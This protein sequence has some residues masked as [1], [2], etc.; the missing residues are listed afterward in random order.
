VTELDLRALGIWR[1]PIPLPGTHPR[2]TVNAWAIEDVDGGLALLD[3]GFDAPESVAALAD[4]LDEGGMSFHSVRR[5][6]L[7]HAHAEHSGG[8]RRVID[9]ADPDVAVHASRAQAVRLRR[10]CRR[11]YPLRDGERL[12]F[13]WFAASAL[14]MPGHTAGLTCLFAED[15]GVF[16]S[17]DHLL[18]GIVP[19]VTCAPAN[20]DL[21]EAYRASLLRLGA[22]EVRVV[23]PGRGA[24]FAGHRRV[25]GEVLASL[26]HEGRGATPAPRQESVRPGACVAEGT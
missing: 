21:R 18:N 24:P 14:R 25:V 2:E 12:R 3:C 19:V 26:A 7:S 4:G 20:A 23:L 9:L 8:V 13:R 16:F 22:L 11:A 1:I 10:S 6:I 15:E 17:S 5:V